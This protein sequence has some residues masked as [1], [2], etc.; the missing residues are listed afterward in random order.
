MRRIGRSTWWS[1]GPSDGSLQGLRVRDTAPRIKLHDKQ[2]DNGQDA[3]PPKQTAGFVPGDDLITGLN[4]AAASRSPRTTA[5]IGAALV[6]DA[7]RWCL[8]G[9]LIPSG[10]ELAELPA[11]D[12]DAVFDSEIAPFKTFYAK[13]VMG[14]SLGIYAENHP[15]QPEE[16]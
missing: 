15:G 1:A 11:E 4:E 16:D 10:A 12:Q 3:S 2:I 6:E 14:Y 13:I 5:I 7:L 8:C 9:F